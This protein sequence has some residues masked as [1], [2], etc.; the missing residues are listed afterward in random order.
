MFCFQSHQYYLFVLAAKLA[1]LSWISVLIIY[2]IVFLNITCIHS[3]PTE[4]CGYTTMNGLITN[5]ISVYLHSSS[6]GFYSKTLN[7]HVLVPL[8]YWFQ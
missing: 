6:L 5:S 2:Y 7:Y 1:H 3:M 4:L 8:T